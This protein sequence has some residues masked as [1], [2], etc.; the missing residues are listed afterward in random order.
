MTERLPTL[1]EIGKDLLYVPRPAVYLSLA[2]PFLLTIGFFVFA[3]LGWWFMALLCPVLLS[4]F[5]YAS[6]S[7][8]LVHRTLGLSKSANEALLCTVESLALRS[9][10]GYRASHFHHHAHFPSGDDLEGA[11][12]RMSFIRAFADGVT[13]QPRIW[14]HAVRTSTL[15][16]PWIHAE[17]ALVALLMALS[18]VALLWTP[19]PVIYC[20]LVIVGS[21]IYPLMTSWIPHDSNGENELRQTRLFRGHVVRWLALEHLYHLEHHLYPQVPH[22]R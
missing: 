20:G 18:L 21:W 5:T 16:R 7:H 14:C 11:A 2:F 17:G 1:R 6:I 9:G 10:H 4:F 3:H 13:L 8:D 22:H 15:D 19:L 12:A